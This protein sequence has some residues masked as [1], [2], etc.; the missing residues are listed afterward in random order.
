[1]QRLGVIVLVIALSVGALEALIHTVHPSTD[2]ALGPAAAAAGPP[3]AAPRPA[4]PDGVGC[5]LRLDG[6]YAQIGLQQSVPLES[7]C[8]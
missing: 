1:M 4:P 8:D 2:T 5:G 6:H 7:P 3:V